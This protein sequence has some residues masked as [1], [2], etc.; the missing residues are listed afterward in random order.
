MI[1]CIITESGYGGHPKHPKVEAG[2]VATMHGLDAFYIFELGKLQDL[3]HINFEMDTGTHEMHARVHS[4]NI[5]E[6]V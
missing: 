6:I 4:Q 5:N 1:K 2:N 3:F